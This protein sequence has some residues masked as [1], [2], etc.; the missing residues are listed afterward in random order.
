MQP[1]GGLNTRNTINRM[2]LAMIEVGDGCTADDLRL[3]GFRTEQIEVF[4]ARATELA[5]AMAQA[6]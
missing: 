5:T 6:A 1:N 2:A 4:G 3:K